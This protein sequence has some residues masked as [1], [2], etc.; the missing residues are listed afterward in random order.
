VA[1][2]DP[3]FATSVRTQPPE[4][5]VSLTTWR[6][7]A[8]EPEPVSHTLTP[9]APW[10][11][12]APA[13]GDRIFVLAVRNDDLGGVL[14]QWHPEVTFSDIGL[15]AAV[16]R[17][18][19]GSLRA[20]AT[21]LRVPPVMAEAVR[22]AWHV[23]DRAAV[24]R[25]G[26]RRRDARHAMGDVLALDGLAPGAH[27]VKCQVVLEDGRVLAE[28]GLVVDVTPATPPLDAT[29]SVVD[30]QPWS[31]MRLAPHSA[32]WRPLSGTLETVKGLQVHGLEAHTGVPA[33]DEPAFFAKATLNIS[34]QIRMDRPVRTW[35]PAELEAESQG[36]WA[37]K[38]ETPGLTGR[39]ASGALRIGVLEGA[40]VTWRQTQTSTSGWG[41]SYSWTH[42]GVVTSRNAEVNVRASVSVDAKRP[43]DDAAA[44]AR[45]DALVAQAEAIIA[46]LNIALA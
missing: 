35:T 21:A 4:R 13:P 31:K 34:G 32:A 16:E 2:L 20:V 41:T 24:L 17:S 1:W 5:V 11:V 23:D 29:P 12:I 40:F 37:R 8:P 3:D 25:M 9:D 46:S 15:Q 42:E 28:A 7:G 27:R 22:F 43:E 44:L 39:L 6:A 36:R 18:N 19:D 26:E 45:F 30:G 14:G 38:S 10:T 33:S